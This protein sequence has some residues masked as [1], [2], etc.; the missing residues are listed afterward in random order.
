[1][2]PP[3]IANKLRVVYEIEGHS[4]SVWEERPH[5]RRSGELHHGGPHSVQRILSPVSQQECRGN[6]TVPPDRSCR[7]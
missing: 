4:V 3:Q 2:S 1:M 7:G 5:W 6:H